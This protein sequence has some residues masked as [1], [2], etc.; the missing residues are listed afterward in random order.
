M[1][2]DTPTRSTFSHEVK[3]SRKEEQKSRLKKVFTG[4][5]TKKEKKE[6]WMH[7]I[8][9]EGVKEGVLVQDGAASAPVVRY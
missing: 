6:D 1:S 3:A 9:K 7:R 8:E 4:W 5:M 2:V